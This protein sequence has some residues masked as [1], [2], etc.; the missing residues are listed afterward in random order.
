[1]ARRTIAVVVLVPGR[2]AP[3]RDRQ[4]V[5]FESR[6]AKAGQTCHKAQ[7]AKGHTACQPRAQHESLFAALERSELAFA[8]LIAA[9]PAASTRF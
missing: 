3:N 4:T 8:A 6:L 1:M 9:L 2:W 5:P 7:P